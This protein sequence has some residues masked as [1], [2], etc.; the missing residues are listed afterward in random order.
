[1][2]LTTKQERRTKMQLTKNFH[3][4]E[5]LLN[6]WATP[7]EQAR[8]IKSLTGDVLENL[9]ELAKNLQVLS[10]DIGNVPIKI[11]IGFRPLWWE[12]S[13]KRSGKSQHVTGK[14]ADIVVDG[15]TPVHVAQRIEGLIKSGKMKPGG[16][17]AYPTFT[18]YDIR[19]INA[20]W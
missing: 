12:L 3:L 17:N 13:R 19:G 16:I 20:R 5:F 6:Q 14:A 9:K 1:M 8:I 7:E 10:D 11:N 4:D 15:M 18:H 2:D